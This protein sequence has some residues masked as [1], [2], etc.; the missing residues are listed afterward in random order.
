MRG[1]MITILLPNFVRKWK[2]N[3]L[4]VG[5]VSGMIQC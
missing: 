4:E 5:R 1:S 2:C 3:L